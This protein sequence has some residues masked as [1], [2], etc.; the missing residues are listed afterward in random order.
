MVTCTEL[1]AKVTLRDAEPGKE[2]LTLLNDSISSNTLS[3]AIV[4]FIVFLVEFNNKILSSYK[5]SVVTSIYNIIIM[6]R[7]NFSL[8]K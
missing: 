6:R 7:E 4:T 8:V 5:S 3:L 2:R 1:T